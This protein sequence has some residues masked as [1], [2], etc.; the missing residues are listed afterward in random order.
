M[1]SA[2]ARLHARRDALRSMNALLRELDLPLAPLPVK[3]VPSPSVLAKVLRALAR[4]CADGAEAT[5]C[6][7]AL[8]RWKT[9]LEAYNFQA[10]D[11][12]SGEPLTRLGT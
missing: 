9:R 6:E 4:R 12:G 7:A 3:D 11:F 2:N 10:M 1:K 8:R 5:N